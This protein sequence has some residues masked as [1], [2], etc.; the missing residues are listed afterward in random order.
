MKLF[1]LKRIERRVDPWGDL[2]G[3][4]VRAQDETHARELTAESYPVGWGGMDANGAS[5]FLDAAQV[6]C[7][8]LTADGDAGVV[9]NDV[10][11]A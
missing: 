10:W 1:L 7:V 3:C 9:L 8:E 5:E 6:S 11:E 2:M 4:V